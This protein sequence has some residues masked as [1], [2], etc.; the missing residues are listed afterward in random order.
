MMAKQ[1][2]V[3]TTVCTLIAS[4]PP[5]I[6]QLQ[7]GGCVWQGGRFDGHASRNGANGLDGRRQDGDQTRIGRVSWILSPLSRGTDSIP[8]QLKKGV[9]QHEIS[10]Q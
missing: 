7:C 8:V 9:E 5:F 10:D 2:Q 6:T 4:K 3:G 1:A